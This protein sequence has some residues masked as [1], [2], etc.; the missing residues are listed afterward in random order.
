MN[1]DAKFIL[2]TYFMNK[3][4]VQNWDHNDNGRKIINVLDMYILKQKGL[5]LELSSWIVSK[6]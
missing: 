1:I 2:L 5:K 6:N 3:I 4:L